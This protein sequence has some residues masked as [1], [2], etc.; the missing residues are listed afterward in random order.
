MISIRPLITTPALPVSGSSLVHKCMPK[1]PLCLGHVI[2]FS[3]PG[4][5]QPAVPACSDIT[6]H[7]NLVVVSLGQLCP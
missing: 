2:C 4:I 5:L 6:V 7:G 1:S 3:S